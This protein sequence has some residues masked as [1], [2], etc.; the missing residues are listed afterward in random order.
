MID[1]AREEGVTRKHPMRQAVAT[2]MRVLPCVWILLLMVLLG[3]AC[4][5][6]VFSK[7]SDS[8]A[9]ATPSP[10]S[11]TFLY[12]TNNDG[13]VGEFTRST[14][15]GV[16][17]FIGT[18]KAGN[19]SG[20]FGLTAVSSTNNNVYVANTAGGVHQFS[21]NATSGK[22]TALNPSSVK[23][24]TN[25]RWV[26]T[27]STN[28]FAY[29]T[30][31]GSASISQYKI[32]STGA[33][34][35]NGTATGPL[36]NPYAAIASSSTS[37][38][39]LFVSDRANSGTIVTFSIN[40]S[41][42]AL[43]SPA[44]TPMVF[45]GTGMPG[46]MVIDPNGQFLYVTD[47][48]S[49]T[50]SLLSG[51]SAGTLTLVQVYPSTSPGTPSIGLAIADPNGSSSNEFLYTANQSAGTISLYVATPAN[52]A[53]TL[54]VVVATGLSNPT[55]LAVDPAG[56]FLYVTNQTTGNISTYSINAANGALTV[57]GSPIPTETSNSN[58]TPLFM[59][60]GG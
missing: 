29:A 59:T 27:D 58:S 1:R 46:P 17:T 30:N 48:N 52:G 57:V 41:T 8:T 36:A 42:G 44:I 31:F 19:A 26:A 54:P 3:G 35:T 47:V 18:V 7:T 38:N 34:T 12:V 21:F 13:T 6:S 32:N 53:L 20:P 60:F 51:V 33:L 2:L 37:G 56:M 10:G 25:P 15:T 39:F 43:G 9:T 45:S 49:G 22:L 40:T 24:G 5:R 50:V 14:T 11:G 16:L 28:A 55:G 4:G 23:A